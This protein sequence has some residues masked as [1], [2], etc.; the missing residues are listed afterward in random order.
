MKN[1]QTYFNY[2][3]VLK[4]KSYQLTRLKQ[5][6]ESSRLKFTEIYRS[7]NHTLIERVDHKIINSEIFNNSNRD[8]KSIEYITRL[9]FKKEK[10]D[11]QQ[12]MGFKT[13][14][15]NL[16]GNKPFA[17]HA[18]I[19]QPTTDRLPGFCC[20]SSSIRSSGHDGEEGHMKD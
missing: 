11:H 1:K 9:S 5:T 2:A 13:L 17:H 10:E 4:G 7:S 18:I 3:F 19:S 14:L 12:N 8:F 15:H 16:P 20:S 6:T